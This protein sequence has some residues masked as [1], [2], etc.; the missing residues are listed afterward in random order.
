[1]RG[2]ENEKLEKIKDTRYTSIFA[3]EKF[4][5]ACFKNYFMKVDD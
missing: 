2:T 4:A 5:F 1:M 3:R